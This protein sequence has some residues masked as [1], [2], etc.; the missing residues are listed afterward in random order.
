M[1]PTWLSAFVD[2]APE[3]HVAGLEFWRDVT[4]FEVSLSR[5]GSGEFVTLVPTT[6]GEYLKVQRLAS[7]P[8]RIHL[9]LHV[10]DPRVAAD[11]AI[12]A[13]A[14]EVM[15]PHRAELGHVV[16]TSPGGLTFCYVGHTGGTRPAP[17]SW[18][19]HHSMVYQVCIDIP[20]ESWDSESAFWVESLGGQLEALRARPEFSWVRPD[21]RVEQNWALDVLLQR[22]EQPSG[23]V[24]AHLD[25]GTNNR[26]L[27]DA[28]HIELGAELLVN[29]EFWTLM[30]D[31]AGVRYCV[32]GRDPSTGRLG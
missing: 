3:A 18:G 31:P 7:G 10:A 5:G 28:R 8:S 22:V 24:A 12:A 4:G 30:R 13:G 17:V 11:V 19:E 20:G 2:L 6:G 25:L 32:T 23:V 26:V 1:T 9:D 21:H 29:E 16:L 27:E 14:V 15:D